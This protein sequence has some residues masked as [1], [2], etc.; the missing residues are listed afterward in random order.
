M[1]HRHWRRP[2]RG[3]AVDLGVM[4]TA[5][6][7]FVAPQPDPA[8]RETAIATAFRD[9]RLLEQFDGISTGTDED[10]FARHCVTLPRVVVLDIHAKRRCP[11]GP[12]PRRDAC[13]A[14]KRRAGRKDALPADGSTRR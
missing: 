2:L 11:L 12:D 8:D 3:L 5:Y 14:L 13:N 10:E 7:T 4:A 6:C 1:G 9:A